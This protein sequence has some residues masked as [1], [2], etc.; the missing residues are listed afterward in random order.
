MFINKSSHATL[1][2]KDL[3]RL[4]QGGWPLDKKV[5]KGWIFNSIFLLKS[6]KSS[7]VLSVQCKAVVTN[8]EIYLPAGFISNQNQTH[9]F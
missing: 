9:L 8:L 4:H 3:C 1:Y 7:Y 6:E 2:F 5:F